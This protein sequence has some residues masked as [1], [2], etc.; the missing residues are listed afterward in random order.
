MLQGHVTTMW[1]LFNNV[2][3]KL[4]TDKA[5]VTSES[6]SRFSDLVS[7]KGKMLC[8]VIPFKYGLPLSGWQVKLSGR[9]C[10]LHNNSGS[11]VFDPFY[12]LR[13]LCQVL[14]RLNYPIR[15]YILGFGTDWYFSVI[16]YCKHALL[17]GITLF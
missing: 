14:S 8:G 10:W 5:T 3:S 13:I 12:I 9:F 1:K 17:I 6:S 7:D 2:L 4:I 16:L 15:R 11:T